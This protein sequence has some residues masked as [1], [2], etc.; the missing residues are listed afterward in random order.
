MREI[1][2]RVCGELFT[3]RNNRHLYCSDKCRRNSDQ[4]RN[5]ELRNKWQRE[6]G[7]KNR[8]FLQEYK[9]KKGCAKCGYK[10]HHAAL[11]FN[12]IDPSKKSGNIAEKAT[13]W[14]FKKLLKEVEK[15]EVLCANCHRVHTW[16]EIQ[17]AKI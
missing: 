2:C 1:S 11:E 10:E 17:K 8:K 15:C 3:A 13:N 9:L 7:R 6:N 12:H 4:K 14:S 5:Q 16:N